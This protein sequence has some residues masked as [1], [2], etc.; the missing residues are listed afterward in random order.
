MKPGERPPC[1]TM[2]GSIDGTMG[3]DPEH[4]GRPCRWLGSSSLALIGRTTQTEYWELAM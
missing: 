4:Q 3:S 1:P 2:A